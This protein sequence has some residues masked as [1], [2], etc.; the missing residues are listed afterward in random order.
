MSGIPG[1][2]SLSTSWP[3]EARSP[4]AA[5]RRANGSKSARN[6]SSVYSERPKRLTASSQ[7]SFGRIQLVFRLASRSAFSMYASI[8][9]API[10][11]A[12]TSVWNR[13]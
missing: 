4:T 2:V 6:A 1:A 5:T 12:P 3:S 8:R 13:K 11:Q 7:S 10:G 9:S